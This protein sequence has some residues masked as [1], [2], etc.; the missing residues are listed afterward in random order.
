MPANQWTEEIWI[1]SNNKAFGFAAPSYAQGPSWA[2]WPNEGQFGLELFKEGLRAT[3][4][5]IIVGAFEEHRVFSGARVDRRFQVQRDYMDIPIQDMSDQ[6]TTLYGKFESIYRWLEGIDDRF[7]AVGGR[8]EAVDGQLDAINGR[9]DDL[10]HE[11]KCQ[12]EYMD[13]QFG[14]VYASARQLRAMMINQ[15]GTRGG[16]LLEPVGVYRNGAYCIPDN[17]PKTVSEFWKLR[18][19][20]KLPQLT[21]LSLFYNVTREELI[22]PDIDDSDSEGQ[23]VP[24]AS[25]SLQQLIDKFPEMAHMALAD[26]FGL[27]YGKISASMQRLENFKETVIGKRAQIEESSRDARKFVRS[28]E[29]RAAPSKQNTPSA[30]TPIPSIFGQ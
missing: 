20:S 27:Q 7:E 12:R 24:Y 23:E 18:K 19:H 30:F 8:F 17:F 25:V 10:G 4:Y 26:R 14:S 11:L 2:T 1:S 3:G 13:D 22:E 6:L 29:T 15:N 5:A 28:E 16:K 9:L 21:S